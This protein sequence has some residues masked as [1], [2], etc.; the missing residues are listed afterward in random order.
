VPFA[1]KPTILPALPLLIALIAQFACFAP[2]PSVSGVSVAEWEAALESCRGSVVA[3]NVWAT[4]CKECVEEFPGFLELQPRYRE[5]GVKFL[6]L[7]LDDVGPGKNVAPVESFLR[8]QATGMP[9]YLLLEPLTD[10]MDRLAIGG[11]PAVL[12][13][14]PDGGV[15]FRLE[16][17]E[18]DSRVDPGDVDAAIQS[19]L[20]EPLAEPG[21]AVS[22]G[23]SPARSP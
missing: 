9:N 17:D 3:V 8:M 11:L 12:I 13:Y 21:Q 10:A 6:T 22:N 18:F 5:R 1:A 20:P 15:A 2:A 4:W 14:R 16:G 7:S 19:L 23:L